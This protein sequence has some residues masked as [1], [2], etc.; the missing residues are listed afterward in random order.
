MVMSGLPTFAT[1]STLTLATCL[2]SGT[3]P[4]IS[5]PSSAPD[6]YSERL[7]EV[8]PLPEMVPPVAST[9]TTGRSTAGAGWAAHGA[10]HKSPANHT[11]PTIRN[12]EYMLHLLTRGLSRVTAVTS[13]H[14]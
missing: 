11:A 6:L 8:A 2:S 1:C 10:T 14:G 13:S 7:V 12:C 5:S 4:T 3:A 9:Q